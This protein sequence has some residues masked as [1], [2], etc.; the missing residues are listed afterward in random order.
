M[1]LLSLLLL[2]HSFSYAG[3]KHFGV[4][5]IPYDT[6]I[7]KKDP[8]TWIDDFKLF[9]TAVYQND[10]AAVKQYF[11]FPLYNAGNEIWMLVLKEPAYEKL[12]GKKELA[13][14]E[15]DLDKYYL[16]IFPP[17]FK[18]SILKIKTDELFRTGNAESTELKEA[19]TS[20][21]MYASYDK[22]TRILSL[23]LAYN[24]VIKDKDG[25]VEDGGE[26]NVIYNF[27]IDKAGHIIFKEVRLAG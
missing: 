16:K 4:A 8:G 10:K 24:T 11:K 25:E 1:K 27:I 7:N 9:R 23:N 14:T 3:A 21:K 6:V 19:N 20:Y 15:K 26:S 5:A 12:A 2:T 18:K 13:F 22:K 17:A